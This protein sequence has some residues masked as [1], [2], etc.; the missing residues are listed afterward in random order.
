MKSRCHHRLFSSEQFND[1]LTYA[2]ANQTKLVIA[3]TGYSQEQL[4]Q[5]KEAS[6]EIAIF[7]SYNTSFGVQMVTK[8]LRQFAKEFY[9]AGYDIEILENIIIRKL[10]HLQELLNYYMKLWLRKLMA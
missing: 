9:D 3:T 6:K 7:Q 5:I 2:L 8:M 4:D 1:I 10:M